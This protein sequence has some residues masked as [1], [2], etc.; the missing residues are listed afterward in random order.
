MADVVIRPY[1]P[2]DRDAVY[3]ICLRTAAAGQ[4]AT[5]LHRDPDVV[6]DVFAGPYVHLEPDFAF[7]LDDGGRAV[8]YVLGA[9]DTARFAA[10]LREKW[11]PLV[12][13]K[14]PDP[15]GHPADRDQEYAYLL[16]HP[17]DM[18]RPALADYPAHLHIDLL[19]DYRRSGNGRRLI[20]T[21]LTA[22]RN[23]G[24]PRVHLGMIVTNTAAR[25]FYDRLGFTELDVPNA[26][27]I[28]YLGRSTDIDRLSDG[29][30]TVS[31]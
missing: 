15:G 29:A 9:P 1:R 23:A 19:A 21:L 5:E 16:H 20:V 26:G 13:A 12:G 27:V 8:G 7:V 31:P 10:D 18:V 22:L 30:A 28:T 24:V 3:G 2:T 11:L 4:D 6:A 14:H 17:E 25:A